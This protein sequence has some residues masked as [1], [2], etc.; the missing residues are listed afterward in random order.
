GGGSQQLELELRQ[1]SPAPAQV[2]A[3]R[4]HAEAGAGRV[5]ERS[6]EAVLVELTGVD[7]DDVHVRADV[8]RECLRASRMH[9]DRGD[10]AVQHRRLAAW[11]G[12]GVED[13]L[14]L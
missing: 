5:D 1:R 3:A 12:A 10:L 9:L 2:G 4:E 6:V 13:L 14:A 8:L 11:G 7:V